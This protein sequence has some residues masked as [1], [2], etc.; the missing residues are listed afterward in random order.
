MKIDR[1]IF[2]QADFIQRALDNLTA[3]LRDGAVLVIVVV[4]VFLM[5][6]RAAGITLLAIPLSLVAAVLAMQQF[7]FTIN[8]MSM[9]GL[10][11]AIG[12]LV[13]DAIID[14]ENVMRR[15][16]ENAAAG[17]RTIAGCWRWC[18]GRVAKFAARSFSPRS[19]SSSSFSRCFSWAA[20]KDACCGRWGSL[21][22]WRCAPHWSS[23]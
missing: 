22:W 21:T 10:A 6:L 7:G 1:Q 19:S 18:I 12:A 3:A 15:L 5:N 14:V 4:L 17:G 23:H 9:G 11:I 8:S 16:R 20:W 13:D 2:R